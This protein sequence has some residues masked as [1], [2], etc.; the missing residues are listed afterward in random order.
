VSSTE[1]PCPL[2]VSLTPCLPFPSA[3]TTCCPPI[4]GLVRAHVTL[5]RSATRSGWFFVLQ[6]PPSG[7]LLGCAGLGSPRCRFAGPALHTPSGVWHRDRWLHLRPPDPGRGGRVP[8][9]RGLVVQLIV[10][11]LHSIQSHEKNCVRRPGFLRCFRKGEVF[12]L[13]STSGARRCEDSWACPD[14]RFGCTPVSL[15]GAVRSQ[16]GSRRPCPR[17]AIRIKGGDPVAVAP[18][19]PSDQGDA[20]LAGCVHAGARP[21]AYEA[22]RR[23]RNPATLQGALLGQKTDRGASRE[24]PARPAGPQYPEVPSFWLVPVPY[25]AAGALSRRP[26]FIRGQPGPPFSRPAAPEPDRGRRPSP[27]GSRGSPLP[28]P[29]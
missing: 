23:S 6:H 19:P 11:A 9:R 2:V 10:T 4:P 22:L 18:G 14:P 17:T 12:R 21:R 1:N 5:V 16:E 7:G 13:R 28:L 27:V 20:D 25:I 8:A 15:R 29:T 26:L 24:P 3:A